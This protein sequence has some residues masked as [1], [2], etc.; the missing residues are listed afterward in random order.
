MPIE[1]WDAFVA[2]T[3]EL[4]QATGGGSAGVAGGAGSGTTNS[5]GLIDTPASAR[6]PGQTAAE[7][8]S[9]QPDDYRFSHMNELPA[10]DPGAAWAE[11]GTQ[12]T[13][14]GEYWG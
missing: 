3:A 6:Q 12:I 5:R 14:P 11:D 9:A 2:S 4:S 1:G 8:F 7:W 13:N 10:A